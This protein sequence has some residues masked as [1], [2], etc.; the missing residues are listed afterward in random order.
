MA[1]VKPLSFPER[2]KYLTRLLT[3]LS[4]NN[5][6]LNS[7]WCRQDRIG[8]SSFYVYAN[9]VFLTLH[10]YNTGQIHHEIFGFRQSPRYQGQGKDKGFPG[11]IK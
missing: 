3:F 5:L 2:G 10:H 11:R 8:A 4:F 7:Q 1:P 6:S 9:G